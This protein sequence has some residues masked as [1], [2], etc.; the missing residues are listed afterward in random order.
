MTGAQ[1]VGLNL[2]KNDVWWDSGIHCYGIFGVGFAPKANG[3][4]VCF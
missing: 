3:T 4:E 1:K 2:S